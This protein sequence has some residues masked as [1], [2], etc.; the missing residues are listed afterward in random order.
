LVPSWEK[1]KG[2]A[3]RAIPRAAEAALLV[4]PNQQWRPKVAHWASLKGINE[5]IFAQNTTSGIEAGEENRVRK[6]PL[7][8][9]WGCFLREILID[10]GRG[11]V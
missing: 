4:M 8:E 7:L 1:E 9:I 3:E 5:L 11:G 2:L 6:T 10:V